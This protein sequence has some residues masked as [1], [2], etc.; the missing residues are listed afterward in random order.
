MPRS[1]RSRCPA[2]S[3]AA[4][5]WAVAGLALSAILAA[6]GGGGDDAGPEGSL[7][8]TAAEGRQVAI[9]SGCAGCHGKDG[10]GGVGPA[11]TGLAGSTVTLADGTTVV[12]DDDY[13]RRSI[14]D[15]EADIPAGY[16]IRMP[17]NTL[18]TPEQVDAIV[19]YI[20]ALA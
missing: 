11:W 6:C 14:T 7:A 1:G 3:R 9:D 2:A 10:Q 5:R 13:L 4:A 15:P 18:V 20:K 8:P 17:K 19:A 16:T 12:A